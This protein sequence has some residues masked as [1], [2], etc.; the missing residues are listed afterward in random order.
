[1]NLLDFEGKRKAWWYFFS[2]FPSSKKKK[3]TCCGSKKIT[4]LKTLPL[5][6]LF[7]CRRSKPYPADNNQRLN[8]GTFKNVWFWIVVL[9]CFGPIH[10]EVS[11]RGVLVRLHSAF[12][13]PH[14]I[15]VIKLTQDYV[16]LRAC[17][18]PFWPPEVDSKSQSPVFLAVGWCPRW[19]LCI[20]FGM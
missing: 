5:F 10:K 16:F 3:K 11:Q 20:T 8:Q 4:C 6:Y 15:Y 9:C 17:K 14:A 7:F 13:G 12:S 2:F 19:L 1:M 18:H